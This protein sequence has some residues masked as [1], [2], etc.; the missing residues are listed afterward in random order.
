MGRKIKS[1]FKKVAVHM[2]NDTMALMLPTAV[3]NVHGVG[4]TLYPQNPRQLLL[5]PVFLL[6]VC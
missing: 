1:R 5:F 2:K 3:T 4:A 6:H